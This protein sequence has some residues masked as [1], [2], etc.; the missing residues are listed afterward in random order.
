MRTAGAP[1]KGLF[2]GWWIVVTGLLIMVLVFAPAINLAG[3]FI[4]PLA[5]NF[6]VPRTVATTAVTISSLAGMLAGLFSGKLFAR[7]NIRRIVMLAMVGVAVCYFATVFSNS[8]VVL[9]AATILRGACN[10]VCTILPISFLVNNWFGKR[11]RG[12]AFGVAMMGSGIGAMLLTPITGAILENWGWRGGYIFFGVLALVLLPLVWVTY[13]HTPAEKGLTCLGAEADANGA[14]APQDTQGIPAKRAMR[15]AL[16]WVLIATII[17][18]SGGVQIWLVNS[19]SYLTDFDFDVLWVSFVLSIGSASMTAGKFIIGAI[20]DK[21]GAK[22]GTIVG[23][24]ALVAGYLL[25]LT[26]G[27]MPMMAYP[28][29]VIMGFGLGTSTV[30]TSL[31]IRELFGNRDFVTL[32]GFG[33]SSLNFGAFFMPIL[34]SLVYDLSGSYVPAWL[35]ACVICVLAIVG[36]SMAYAL[37]PRVMA[38]Y[39]EQTP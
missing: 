17:L 27:K 18:M 35:A 2:F 38:R 16:F 13:V 39:G 37:Q 12:R 34:A 14:P 28:T 3:L 32:S 24:C 9:F 22:V 8:L 10:T 1:K 29:T 25:S 4:K 21:A 7:G 26:V 15:T 33:Q 31:L 23:V 11:V 6:G 36:V 19:A 20:C 30:V 5:E